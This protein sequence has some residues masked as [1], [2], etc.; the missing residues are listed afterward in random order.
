MVSAVFALV[1]NAL[2]FYPIHQRL[3]SC[4][5]WTPEIPANEADRLQALRRCAFWTLLKEE[6][7]TVLPDWRSMSFQVPIAVITLV[8]RHRQWFKSHRGLAATETSRQVSFCGHT[9]LDQ[10][11]MIVPNVLQDAR[12][13]DNP[14]VVGDPNIRFYA[15]VPLRSRDG[16]A[17]GVLLHIEH[18]T[19]ISRI[20]P[21]SL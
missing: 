20:Q 6:R 18:E 13:A 7:R 8:D 19:K 10:A 21:Q 16:Y 15:G 4:S 2:D 14:L 3:M 12:F 9:I 17:P 11:P 5:C 1:I